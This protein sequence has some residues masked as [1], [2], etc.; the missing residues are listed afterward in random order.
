M[1]EFI[2]TNGSSKHA[3]T[4]KL[5]FTKTALENI[6]VTVNKTGNQLG[7]EEK[8]WTEDITDETSGEGTLIDASFTVPA[9]GTKYAYVLVAIEDDTLDA[10]F[11]GAFKWTLTN[12]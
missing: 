4:A 6:T 11:A 1:F 3:Y 2:F 12:V 8:Q 7:V 5:D 9:S 10:S